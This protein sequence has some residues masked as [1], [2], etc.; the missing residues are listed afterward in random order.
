MSD[1]SL[2]HP[3]A[4]TGTPAPRF[5]QGPSA[6]RDPALP[7]AQGL[8]DP[9]NEKDSCGVGFVADMRNRKSHA[10]VEQGL[11]ILKNLDHRGAVG[12]DPK[13]GDGC[14]ILVQ[15]PHRFFSEEAKSLGFELPD[16]GAYGVGHL[17]MP[18]DP[19]GFATVTAMVEQPIHEQG[20]P[21]LGWRDVP[22]DNSDLGVTVLE[23][24]PRHRQ[25]FVGKP[26]AAMDQETFERRLFI[27]RKVIS[28]AVYDLNDPKTKGYYP[29]C[30]S[31]RTIVY[32]GLVL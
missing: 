16:E 13:M 19:E 6:V 10:I 14:G 28:N 26:S 21:L 27:A 3:E 17:F 23:S 20:L 9:K 31:S 24:E 5:T 11:S 32:K 18:R 2:K 25:I 8:Y 1:V 7:E 12:A 4:P 15:M 29:V 22:I 30:L